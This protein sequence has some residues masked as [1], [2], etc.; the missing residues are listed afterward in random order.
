[1]SKTIKAVYAYTVVNP[2]TGEEGIAGLITPQGA[3][4]LIAADEETLEEIKPLAQTAATM[5]GR[6]VQ[7]S[8]FSH[9][10]RIT[11]LQPQPEKQDPSDLTAVPEG[12]PNYTPRLTDFTESDG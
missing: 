2:E 11:E 7:L 8:E 3:R 6:P 1:M 10:T 4:P 9:R 12:D 5:M